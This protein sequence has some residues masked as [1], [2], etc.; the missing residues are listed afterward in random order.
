VDLPQ[1]VDKRLAHNLLDPRQAAAHNSTAPST[2]FSEFGDLKK[3]R[4]QQQSLW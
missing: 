1:A 4:K 3:I 2:S